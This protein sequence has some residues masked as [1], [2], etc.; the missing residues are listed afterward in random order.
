MNND[1]IT[2]SNQ[3]GV[4]LIPNTRTE[5]L[6]QLESVSSDLSLY[7]LKAPEVGRAIFR[8]AYIMVAIKDA[9]RNGTVVPLNDVRQAL[10]KGDCVFERFLDGKSITSTNSDP[11]A[12]TLDSDLVEAS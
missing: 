2:P 6:A 8:S 12:D 3:S 11:D 4:Q 1:D 5:L 7:L 10:K 9:L